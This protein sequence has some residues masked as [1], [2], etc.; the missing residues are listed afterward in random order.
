MLT[1]LEY[2]L[3][4]AFAA[5]FDATEAA[6][7]DEKSA[8]FRYE[9]FIGSDFQ[10]Q[11]CAFRE[12]D[13]IG[14]FAQRLRELLREATADLIARWIARDASLFELRGRSAKLI[15]ILPEI[16]DASGLDRASLA[17]VG[18]D[19]IDELQ[20]NISSSLGLNIS[21]TV[22]RAAGHAGVGSAIA[23]Y[24]IQAPS[25]RSEL[26][27][28]AA[29][30]SY[31]DRLRLNC[32][33]D[34]KRL[35]TQQNQFGFIPGEAAGIILFT[36]QTDVI[37]SL[38]LLGAGHEVEPVKEYQE[39]D[40]VFTALSEAAFMAAESAWQARRER[41]ISGWIADWNN[42]RYR[43]TELSFAIHRLNPTCLQSDL[44]PVYPA[45]QFGDIGAAYGCLAIIL[46]CSAR[47]S[48]VTL[49]REKAVADADQE[50]FFLVSSSSMLS[51]L[52]SAIVLSV[53]LVS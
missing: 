53:R 39:A 6:L 45:M 27:M 19:L 21:G 32:L 51:G 17:V 41:A 26:V 28:V 8:L 48:F 36:R 34:Q 16:D 38:R 15:L 52:R 33:N 2:G 22:M 42:S 31:S 47:W 43:A 24:L 9:T 44:S 3:T 13:G 25:E 20:N 12:K 23:D 29:V 50:R 40:S 35:F 46:S 11:L 4:T 18:R 30:D 7:E 14:E 1:L 49:G 5:G 37:S 10:P